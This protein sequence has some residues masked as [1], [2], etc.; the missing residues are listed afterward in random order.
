MLSFVLSRQSR[1]RNT[2][3][4]RKRENTVLKHNWAQLLQVFGSRSKRGPFWLKF[5]QLV[6]DSQCYILNGW[7]VVLSFCLRVMANWLLLVD[8]QLFGDF[9][10]ILVTMM[11]SLMYELVGGLWTFVR[12]IWVSLSLNFI[13]IR[14]EE[15]VDSSH[16]PW[17]LLFTLKRFSTYNLCVV[18]FMLVNFLH[19]IVCHWWIFVVTWVELFLVDCLEVL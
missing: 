18:W 1:L 15:R 4:Q 7:I 3:S 12:L 6:G 10:L 19:Y 14:E 9:F 5:G 11:L 8:S 16:V 2:K 13:I 17:F